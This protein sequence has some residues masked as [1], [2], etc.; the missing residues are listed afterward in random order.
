[1]LSMQNEHESCPANQAA[2]TSRAQTWRRN[3]NAAAL[4]SSAEAEDFFSASADVPSARQQQIRL[5]E[6]PRVAGCRHRRAIGG[7][8][9]VFFPRSSA[10]Q[11]TERTQPAREG[12]TELPS[13]LC[14]VQLRPLTRTG[15]LCDSARTET[16]CARYCRT[17]FVLRPWSSLLGGYRARKRYRKEGAYPLRVHAPES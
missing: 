2:T 6:V 12:L 10:A 14:S 5:K 4:A 3:A 1:M 8:G 9:C 7:H 17:S 11:E 13:R 16:N 15:Q